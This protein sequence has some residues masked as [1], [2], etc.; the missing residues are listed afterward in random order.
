MVQI[1]LKR[2]MGSKA[3]LQE[4]FGAECR[5]RGNM[6]LLFWVLCHFIG[7]LHWFEVDLYVRP[8]FP[9]RVICV[10][11]VAQ[12]H[13]AAHCNIPATH[14]ITLQHTATHRNTL[15]NACCQ[16]FPNQCSNRSP[17]RGVFLMKK[18]AHVQ[19]WRPP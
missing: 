10:A 19:G 11:Q 15:Q 16:I 8:A 18:T 2:V 12:Y 9:F 7:V 6:P 3:R 1:K 4:A 13:A 5:R 17:N 14:C